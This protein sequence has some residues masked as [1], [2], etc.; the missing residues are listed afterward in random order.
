MKTIKPKSHATLSPSA[1]KRWMTCPG[2][3]NLIASLDITETP[4]KF[5]AE[6]TVAHEVGELCLRNRQEPQEYIGKKFTADGFTFTVTQEMADAVEVYTDYV[7]TVI[8]T[9]EMAADA[10][11]NM[12]V[13][14]R[15]SLEHYGVEGLNGGTSDTMLICHEHQFLEVVDYKHGA[16]VAVDAYSGDP[17]MPLDLDKVNTQAMSYGLGAL[18]E[19]GVDEFD[20][21]D[22]Y[23]TIVQPRAIHKDGPI[24]KFRLKSSDVYEWADTKLIPAA[25]L[26]HEEDAPLVASEEGCRFCNAGGDCK[27]RYNMVQTTAMVDFESLD[28]KA[29]PLLPDPRRL[30]ADQKR[31]VMDHADLIR[32]FIVA[33]ENQIKTEVD[34]GSSEYEKHYK[35]VR[36][37]THRKF[38]DIAMD[39]DFSPLLDYLQPED[40]VQTKPES[41]TAIEAKIKRILKEEYGRQAGK[42]A[43]EIMDAVTDKPVGELVIAPQSDG[44]EAVLPSI[45]SDFDGL[46][47]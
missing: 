18:K 28:E 47:D 43:R 42:M 1:S 37:T 39:E 2:S 5:A 8:E 9:A 46:D 20:D 23:L 12:Q 10:T 36:K 34:S 27:A 26:T 32:S 22:I 3:V 40:L 7:R 38:N 14:V 25:L 16:G 41:I 45:V 24:R 21:W 44:R 29:L 35:L 13:E 17:E 30:T 11:V 4:S 19:A 15:C 33:V 6:G 31:M